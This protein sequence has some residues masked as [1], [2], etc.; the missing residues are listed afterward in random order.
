MP[1]PTILLG[2]VLATLY[3]SVFHF[4]R[5][6]SLLK[7]LADLV[8]ALAGFWAGHWLGWYMGWTFW[9]VG[10][11]NAGMGTLGSAVLLLLGNLVSHIRLPAPDETAE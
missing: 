8:L 5:G 7:L 11:L 9:P 10:V 6:G 2:V 3:G 4:L 1:I